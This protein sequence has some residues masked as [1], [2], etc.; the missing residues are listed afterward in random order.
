MS[1]ISLCDICLTH[2]LLL[3]SPLLNLVVQREYSG[4][5]VFLSRNT[6]AF[7]GI[8]GTFHLYNWLLSHAKQREVVPPSG[9]KD[10]PNSFETHLASL[11]KYDT[12]FKFNANWAWVYTCGFYSG[13]VLVIAGFS[14]SQDVV[15]FILGFGF[16]VSTLFFVYLLLW[17][18]HA[19]IQLRLPKRELPSI[20][21]DHLGPSFLH[22]VDLER[23]HIQHTFPSSRVVI[24]CFL[25]WWMFS[26]FGY[27]GLLYPVVI[28]LSC[29]YTKHYIVAEVLGGIAHSLL[30]GG[31]ALLF[32]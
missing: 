2:L 3:L 29:L 23:K 12:H 24:G 30:L 7:L 22:Y 16:V 13:F 5:L 31:I 8:L 20:Q 28:G 10:S 11:E 17:S 21:L 25:G 18:E 9:E 26:L 27:L 1:Q 15:E 19:I 14:S 6:A 32:V 4:Y